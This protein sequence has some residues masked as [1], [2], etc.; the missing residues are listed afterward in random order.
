MLVEM[1]VK[2]MVHNLKAGAERDIDSL[3]KAV[4]EAKDEPSAANV[5]AVAVAGVVMMASLAPLA[6]A[7]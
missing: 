1:K 7:L 3:K 4:E 2:F 5:G 6:L